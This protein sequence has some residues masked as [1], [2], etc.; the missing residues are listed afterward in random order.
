MCKITR[1]NFLKTTLQ[2]SASFQNKRLFCGHLQANTYWKWTF[3]ICCF[4]LGLLTRLHCYSATPAHLFL[5]QCFMQV[6]TAKQTRVLKCRVLYHM[7]SK[8][9]DAQNVPCKTNEK[10]CYPK[11]GKKKTYEG[12]QTLSLYAHV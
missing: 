6:S 3:K 4:M 7:L 2:F 11:W 9:I 10:N 12:N 1:L 8:N 5:L